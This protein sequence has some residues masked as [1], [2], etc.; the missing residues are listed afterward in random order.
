MTIDLRRLENLS[1]PEAEML[2]RYLTMI[3]VQRQDFNG[4]MLTIRRDDLRA[5]ACI[6]GVSVDSATGKLDD[7]GLSL[8]G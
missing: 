5:I 6:L 4:R 7:L 1:G 3:Q 2:N 8:A